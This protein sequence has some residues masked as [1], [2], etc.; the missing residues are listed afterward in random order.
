MEKIGEGVPS[1]GRIEHQ[2]VLF[3]E[4]SSLTTSGGQLE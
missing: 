3:S 4:H 1:V 2:V